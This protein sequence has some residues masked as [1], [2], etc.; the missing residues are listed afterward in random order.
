VA[1]P[2]QQLAN[3]QV[4]CSQHFGMIQLLRVP[5]SKRN[6]MSDSTSQIVQMV[7][8]DQ[9]TN[10]STNSLQRHMSILSTHA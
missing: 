8:A 5:S 9:L 10:H 3:S 4:E 6:S 2:V 1:Y 7:T